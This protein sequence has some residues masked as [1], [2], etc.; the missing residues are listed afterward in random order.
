MPGPAPELVASAAH[1]FVASVEAPLLD[2]EDRHHLER[3]LRLRAGEPVTVS[4]GVGSWRPCRFAAGGGLAPDGAVRSVAP[5]P[6]EVTVAFAPPKG[7]RP[8]LIVQKLTELGAD[9]I[10]PMIT[11][12]T[13]VRWDGDRAAKQLARLAR[14]VREAA[15]QS[16]RVRLPVLEQPTAFA[17]VADRPGAQLAAPGGGRVLHGRGLFLIGPEGGW[18]DEELR[19]P[20][21]RV[22]LGET[23]LRAETAALAACALAVSV[24]AEMVGE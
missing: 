7:D 15:M 22:G 13:V 21:S 4:D 2:D 11:E 24:R 1:V 8:E 5:P 16:R 20:L 18:S 14:I 9:R 12:R 6:Y 3:V 23:V 17:A 19:R 10:V